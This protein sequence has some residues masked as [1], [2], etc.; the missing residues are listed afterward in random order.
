MNLSDLFV[1]QGKPPRPEKGKAVA[2]AGQT[3]GSVGVF[4]TPQSLSSFAVASAVVSMLWLLC[5]RLFPTFGQNPWVAVALAFL[6]GFVIFMINV[7]NPDSRP[8]D[9]W[10]WGIAIGVGTINSLLLA[11]SALGIL[12]T[13]SAL[14]GNHASGG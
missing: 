11:C 6:V 3:R 8:R 13:W 14:A 1:A 2:A 9:R 5:Q 4:I 12:R 7:S 10:G